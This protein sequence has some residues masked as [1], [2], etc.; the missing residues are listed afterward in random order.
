METGFESRSGKLSH[1]CFWCSV[2]SEHVRTSLNI[3]WESDFLPSHIIQ[4]MN[5]LQHT[6]Q[7]TQWTSFIP[8]CWYEQLLEQHLLLHISRLWCARGTRFNSAPY[9]QAYIRVYKLCIAYLTWHSCGTDHVWNLSRPSASN[10]FSPAFNYRCNAQAQRP[11]NKAR[12][13]QKSRWVYTC[14]Y[15]YMYVPPLHNYECR[16]PVVEKEKSWIIWHN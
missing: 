2:Y 1:F 11:G 12:T 6:Y 14:T 3:F 13:E 7:H 9:A 4:L 15:M 5:F 8:G 10:F 16:S